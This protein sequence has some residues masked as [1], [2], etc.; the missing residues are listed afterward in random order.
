MNL[1]SRRPSSL[2]AASNSASRAV[3]T[4]S[5]PGDSLLSPNRPRSPLVAV[6]RYVV[7]PSAA[8]RASV[9]PVP[10]DSSSGCASTHMSR[11]SEAGT[12]DDMILVPARGLLRP[13]IVVR[14]DVLE[15]DGALAVGQDRRFALG[16]G[17]L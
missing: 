16:V 5:G 13:R 4:I 9:P 11:S 3:P 12:A 1:T 8:Y 6:T 2:A 10:N 15:V 17:V 7:T 14:V